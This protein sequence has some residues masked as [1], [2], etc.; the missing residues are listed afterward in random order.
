[1]SEDVGCRGKKCWVT[2]CTY[3]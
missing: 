1:M 3:F 2:L